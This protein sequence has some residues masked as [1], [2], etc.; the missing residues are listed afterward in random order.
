MPS[1]AWGCGAEGMN[2]MDPRPW[3]GG[4]G[5]ISLSHGTQN[6]RGVPTDPWDTEQQGCPHLTPLTAEQ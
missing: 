6:N 2:P 4:N 1:T 3:N 5:D